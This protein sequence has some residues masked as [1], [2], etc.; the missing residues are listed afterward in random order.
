MIRQLGCFLAAC[1]LATA[2]AQ[3]QGM[4]SPPS[5]DYMKSL[6]KQG[7]HVFAQEY[8]DPET[9]Q[10]VKREGF[11]SNKPYEAD[12]PLSFRVSDD[13]RI[14]FTGVTPC[15]DTTPVQYEDF[16]GACKDLAVYGINGDL[17]N[18][19]VVL[20]RSYKDQ[21]GRPQQ[22]ASCY[23]WTYF[24]NALDAVENIEKDLVGLGYWFVAR[25]ADGKPVRP[26]LEY[27][28]QV[29]K[30]GPYGLWSMKPV[31]TPPPVQ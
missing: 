4:S 14:T 21:I 20:C 2:Q 18:A 27:D 25:R 22:D 28:E 3:A 7:Q 11:A 5:K 19:R 8:Y 23:T 24:P 13:R 17:K 15:P 9:R 26:D 6:G 30:T 1:A 16:S 31:P 29:A 12:S 10:V